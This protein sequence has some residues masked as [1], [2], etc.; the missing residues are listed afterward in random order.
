M[1]TAGLPT[2][3]KLYFR[4]DNEDLSAGTYEIDISLSECYADERLP[5]PKPQHQP[6]IRLSRSTIWRNKIACFL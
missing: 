2:F 6:W 1:R 5:N 4:N 3:R